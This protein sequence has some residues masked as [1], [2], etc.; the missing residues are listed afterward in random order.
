MTALEMAD[1]I[2]A[3]LD[4]GAE[5]IHFDRAQAEDLVEWLRAAGWA[6]LLGWDCERR[7]EDGYEKV[8]RL[9]QR[10]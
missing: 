1:I 9:R 4:A 3:S 7:Y 6:E 8:H 5:M 10:K 2:K